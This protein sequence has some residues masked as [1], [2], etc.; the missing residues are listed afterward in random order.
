MTQY[1]DEGSAIVEL[2]HIWNLLTEAACNDPSAV[3]LPEVML[4]V[5]QDRIE[6][7]AG[8]KVRMYSHP[9]SPQCQH[10]VLTYVFCQ[11]TAVVW[12]FEQD[13]SI[14]NMWLLHQA[15]TCCE[16]SL[17]LEFLHQA[18]TCCEWSFTVELTSRL[19]FV[20]TGMVC[21]FLTVPSV[22]YLHVQIQLKV[23][24]YSQQ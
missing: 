14:V 15:C 5:C 1:D 21:V 11:Y 24:L 23:A 2:P 9:G 12:S 22:P 8:R 7:A 16:W 13:K 3:L 18:C 6:A 10:F 4:P 19:T 17:I 20:V